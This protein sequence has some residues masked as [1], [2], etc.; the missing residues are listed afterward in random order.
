LG[1]AAMQASTCAAESMLQLLASALHLGQFQK[2]LEF[3]SST[4]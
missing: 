4:S 1:A 3:F 2:M